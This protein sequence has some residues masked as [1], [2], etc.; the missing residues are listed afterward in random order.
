MRYATDSTAT[1]VKCGGVGRHAVGV[2]N[3]ARNALVQQ[4]TVFYSISYSNERENERENRAA[5]DV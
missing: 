5:S 2:R 3:Y 4:N 1:I